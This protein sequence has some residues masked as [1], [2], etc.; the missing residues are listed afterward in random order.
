MRKRKKQKREQGHED[1][2]SM[3]D[4]SR[5]QSTADGPRDQGAVVLKPEPP[6]RGTFALLIPEGVTWDESR[7]AGI[8]RLDFRPTT[9][10]EK[11][12]RARGRQEQAR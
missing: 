6:R 1:R 12:R 8:I 3:S 2:R 9:R 11:S 4:D 7:E 10:E 5:L